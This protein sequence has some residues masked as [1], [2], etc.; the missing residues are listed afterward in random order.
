[1][2]VKVKLDHCVIHVSNWERSDQFYS[3][4]M[5]AELAPHADGEGL[6]YRLPSLLLDIVDACL[7][8]RSV[9]SHPA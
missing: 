1:M 3:E 9:K 4:V 5:G 7:S 2:T 8:Q 6:A